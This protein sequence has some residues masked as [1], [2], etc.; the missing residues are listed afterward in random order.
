MQIFTQH[1]LLVLRFSV[2]LINATSHCSTTMFCQSKEPRLCLQETLG[3]VRCA[4]LDSFCQA[5][6]PARVTVLQMRLQAIP[7]Q[8]QGEGLRSLTEAL[9]HLH[10]VKEDVSLF[11]C[12]FCSFFILVRIKFNVLY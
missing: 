3:F 9:Y 2:L 10:N 1:C 12:L 11:V 7:S 8:V 4:P 5:E 6:A